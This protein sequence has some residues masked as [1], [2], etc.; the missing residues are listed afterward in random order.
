[1][2]PGTASPLLD[3][4]RTDHVKGS[5]DAR[6]TVIEYGDFECPSCRQAEPAVKLMLSRFERD[7]RLVFRHFP[8]EV[9]H[10]H[11]LAAAEA[12]EAAAAQGQFWPMHD[13]LLE[14]QTH[15]DQ[16]HLE[17]YASQLELDLPRFI[18][19]LDDHVYLQRVREQMATG[20]ALHLHAP[21][22]FFVNGTICD[23]SFGTRALLDEVAAALK[24]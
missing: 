18:A 17:R 1:M 16:R 12:A 6:V 9:P 20:R 19:E 22:S 21:P 11:A 15:L 5:R 23:V 24:R 2:S 8:Q 7:V 13:L 10:P 14:H 4:D 3:V